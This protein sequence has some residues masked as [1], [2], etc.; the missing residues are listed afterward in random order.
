MSG[1]EMQSA[2]NRCPASTATGGA[3]CI[4]RGIV[5]YILLPAAGLALAFIKKY[6]PQSLVDNISNFFSSTSDNTDLSITMSQ[7]HAKIHEGATGC[8]EGTEKSEYFILQDEEPNYVFGKG[9]LD[10]FELSEQADHLFFSMCST[11]IIDGKVATVNHFDDEE[12]IIY[13]SCT[14]KKVEESDV[15]IEYSKA[16]DV[17]YIR[18]AGKFEPTAIALTGNYPN[19]MD[20]IVLN[21]K[22]ADA[23]GDVCPVELPE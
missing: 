1:I 2:C 4:T 6:I 20:N 11:K 23:A 19:I 14:M 5:N 3:F 17:T 9:G 8:I 16:Q 18:I 22:Y 15:S 13:L 21:T 7:D 12:D 10:L